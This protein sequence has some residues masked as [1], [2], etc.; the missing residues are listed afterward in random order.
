M[1][2][3][4]LLEK[5]DKR[6]KIYKNTTDEILLKIVSMIFEIEERLKKV[7][8]LKSDIRTK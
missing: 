5:L 8:N 4:E 7:E 2:T 1:N 3:N 6:R